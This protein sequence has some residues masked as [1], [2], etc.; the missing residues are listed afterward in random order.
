MT[1]SRDSRGRLADWWWTVDRVAL[2]A[3]FGLIA[4][5]LMLA[6]AAS[7]AA[8]AHN[9]VQAGNFHFAAKQI[10]F[11]ALAAVIVVGGSLLN[12]RDLKRAAAITF[13]VALAGAVLVLLTGAEVLGARRWIDLGWLTIQPSEFLKP[14]FAVL[15]AAVLASKHQGGVRK[16]LVSFLLVLIPLA[17]LVLEPDVGQTG[18][19]LAL[20]GAM[21][22]LDG[23]SAVWVGTITGIGTVLGGLAYILIPHVHHRV[24]QF[25]GGGKPGYQSGLALKAFEHGGLAGVGPGA[26]TIKYHIP[27]AHSDFIFAVAGEEFGLV[28]CGIIAALFC[29]LS[30][31]L[32]LRAAAAK[33]K[34]S[35][36]AGAGLAL[37]VALQAFINMGVAVNMLP[38][39][40][41]TLPFISYGGSSL[42][43]VAVTMGFALAVTRQRPTVTTLSQRDT[44]LLFGI[45]EARA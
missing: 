37:I 38:A 43:A 33:D 6:F 45:R 18:L 5:G 44:D 16:E 9:A 42:F 24:E 22:F 26:G 17:L 15:C 10:V 4:I 40:G 41:M 13:V 21:L 1:L 36:L 12:P 14:S 28:L 11:A 31:R 2:F 32:L 7:P 27:Y 3:M 20:W 23:I 19:L 29:A 30:V 34:F 39:K 35:Q 8:T 25:F